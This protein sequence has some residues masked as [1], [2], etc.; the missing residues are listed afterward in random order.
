[1][2]HVFTLL[3]G[4]IG[5]NCK[6]YV[7]EFIFNF[8]QNSAKHHVWN[9]WTLNILL[10]AGTLTY[11]LLKLVYLDLSINCNYVLL[12]I[13]CCFQNL[14]Y[15]SNCYCIQSSWNFTVHLLLICICLDVARFPLYFL[16]SFTVCKSSLVTLLKFLSSFNL[17]S[18]HH[19]LR[20]TFIY[21]YNSSTS[22]STCTM[23]P[24]L[25]KVGSAH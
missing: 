2:Q 7:Y 15:K 8:I 6:R 14:N 1:M 24:I 5:V 21:V 20:K 13:K 16:F 9:K 25:S 23:N 12:K 4:S 18:L 19:Y 11:E 17:K 22:Y 3:A 10:F